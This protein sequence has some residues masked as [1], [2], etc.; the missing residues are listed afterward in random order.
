MYDVIFIDGC[1]DYK[2]VCLDIN[3]Y[4]QML[5]SGGYLVMDDASIYIKDAYGAFLGNP[6]VGKAI[7]DCLDNN[8]DFIHLYSVGHNFRYIVI[9]VYEL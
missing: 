9:K 8:N 2:N 1:H 7:N 6:D 3:N 4:S 5:K